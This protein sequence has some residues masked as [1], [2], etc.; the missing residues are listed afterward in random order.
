VATLPKLDPIA[1]AEV[2][3]PFRGADR[4]RPDTPRD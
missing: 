2:G 3:A 4:L 1:V